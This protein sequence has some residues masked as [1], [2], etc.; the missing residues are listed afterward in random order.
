MWILLGSLVIWPT[1][2]SA[3]LQ[4]QLDLQPEGECV[5]VI[6]TSMA[7]ALG[8]NVHQMISTPVV[9]LVGRCMKFV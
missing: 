1:L 8:L 9:Y 5:W 3:M 2:V 6:L 4:C 7:T